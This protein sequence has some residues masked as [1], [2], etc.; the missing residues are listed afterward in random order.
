MAQRKKRRQIYIQ[1]NLS[2]DAAKRARESCKHTDEEIAL[3]I[4]EENRW[5]PV[6]GLVKTQ[7]A[8]WRGFGHAT[9]KGQNW[10][11]VE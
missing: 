9:P 10:K 6:P 1:S 8:S 7:F 4:V 5:N 3:S 2:L 11:P